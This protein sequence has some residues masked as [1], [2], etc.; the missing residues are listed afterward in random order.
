ME[1][2]GSY[3]KISMVKKYKVEIVGVKILIN[4]N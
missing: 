4:D 2:T 3:G 1:L